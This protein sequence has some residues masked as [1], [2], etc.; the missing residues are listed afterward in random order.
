MFVLN[1]I[2]MA[3]TTIEPQTMDARSL[4]IEDGVT[5]RG[6]YDGN[7]FKHSL[8]YN[9]FVR[10]ETDINLE[11]TRWIKLH[12]PYEFVSFADSY[13]SEFIRKWGADM[14]ISLKSDTDI[15]VG[16]KSIN[17]DANAVGQLKEIRYFG[18]FVWRDDDFVWGNNDTIWRRGSS[19]TKTRH[20][21]KRSLRFR[22]KQIGVYP[23][24]AVIHNSDLLGL[25][26]IT[27]PEPVNDPVLRKAALAD[28]ADF[29]NDLIGY[30]LYFANGSYSTITSQDTSYIYFYMATLMAQNNI[31]WEIIGIKKQQDVE[32][33]DI[34]VRFAPLSEVGDKYQA[35]ERGGNT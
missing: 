3:F 20:F 34:S 26:N 1:L 6:D 29:P 4:Y 2:T 32:I 28:G 7:I 19:V 21:P 15:S 22:R 30:K 27:I 13:G 24:E 9:Y 12:I 14:E 18:S 25:A 8:D 33:I 17:D 23:E 31:E 16:L 11:I 5:Y 35:N 10:Y